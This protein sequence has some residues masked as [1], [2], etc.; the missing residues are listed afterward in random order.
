MSLIDRCIDCPVLIGL[1]AVSTLLT[2]D[3]TAAQA[4]ERS[5][6]VHATLPPLHLESL[7]FDPERRSLVLLGGSP[8]LTGTWG[9]DGERWRQLVDSAH[10]PHPRA[11]APMA[12]DHGR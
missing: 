5:D 9:W 7:A 11:G 12:W 8:E 4:T 1:V 2:A 6:S 10:S 3:P